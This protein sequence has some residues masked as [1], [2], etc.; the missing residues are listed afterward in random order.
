[1]T[2]ISGKGAQDG[3]ATMEE[4]AGGPERSVWAVMQGMKS[5]RNKNDNIF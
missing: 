1:M 5:N 2:W 3:A 4:G